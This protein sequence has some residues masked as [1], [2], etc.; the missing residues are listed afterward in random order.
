MKTTTA[1]IGGLVLALGTS[2][3]LGQ[4]AQP[5][6]APSAT[7]ADPATAGTPADPAADPTATA[8]TT[9]SDPA[10]PSAQSP[11]SD[12]LTASPT[13]EQQQ[14]KGKKRKAKKPQ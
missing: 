4:Q 11:G 10:A 12:P 3:A 7:Q 5:S 2:A 8:A 14:P 1:I 9:P 13:A 6:D